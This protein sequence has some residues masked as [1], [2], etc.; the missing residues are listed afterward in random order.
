MKLLHTTVYGQGPD[1]VLTHGWG[2]H[3][4]IWQ[5][6]INALQD[7]YRLTVI[8][9][10]GHGHSPMPAGGFNLMRLSQMMLDAAPANA[11]W[12]GWS[13]GGMASL[14]AALVN[15]Q[16]IDKII[17]VAAQPQFIKSDDWPHATPDANLALFTETLTKNT[18]QT[19]KRFLGLQVRGT[20]DEKEMLRRIRAIVDE[21]PLPQNEALR[22][23]LD[24]LRTANLRPQLNQ[25]QRPVQLIFGGR[26][27]LVPVATAALVQQLLPQARIDIMKEAGH[28]PF[29]S[30]TTDFLHLIENFI[31]K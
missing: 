29:L 27:M 19:L 25:L 21:R 23:G 8:D 2:L 22:L 24:I 13:L 12:I 28:A 20:T 6:V 4:G 30:H 7:H 17:M 1:L 10:P 11:T 26:D 15:P 16:Q 9:L 14:N 31:E 18:E 5:P 3:G